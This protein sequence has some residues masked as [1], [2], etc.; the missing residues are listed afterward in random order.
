MDWTQVVL[1]FL[2]IAAN[3]F[4]VISLSNQMERK[5]AKSRKATDYFLHEIQDEMKEFHRRLCAIE[6]RNKGK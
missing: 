6:E 5:N 3:I 1:V 2:V 4:S